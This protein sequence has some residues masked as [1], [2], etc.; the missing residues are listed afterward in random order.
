VISPGTKI[1]ILVDN[2]ALQSVVAGSEAL[3]AEPAGGGVLEKPAAPGETPARLASEHGLAFWI[4]S[5]GKRIL[6]D[7]GQGP[8]LARNAPALGVAL[9]ETDVLV[10]SHGHYDHTGGVAQVLRQAPHVDLYCHPGVLQ[11]R[12]SVRE[13]KAKPIGIRRRPLQALRKLPPERLHWVQE[14]MMLSETVGITGPIP[15]SNGYEDTGGPFYLDKKGWRPDP[16]EDDLALWIRTKRGLVVCLGCAHAGAVSTLD[17]VRGLDPGAGVLAML[18][19]FH[20]VNATEERL[21]ETIAA[22]STS[23]IPLVVPSHCT[24]EKALHVL[25]EVL[26]EKVVTGAAGMTFQF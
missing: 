24:G 25:A 7:T 13:G 17:Y 26:G 6:F 16:L 3:Q 15:R 22:L 12:Y 23:Q 21:D 9:A 18:G 19:G 20:L 8:A 4:E 10:L 11:T 5:G 1:T 2:N 14:P